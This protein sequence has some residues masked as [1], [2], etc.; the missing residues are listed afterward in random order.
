MTAIHVQY[1]FG[2]ESPYMYSTPF[3]A[4]SPVVLWSEPPPGRESRISYR[5]GRTGVRFRLA[6]LKVVL[7]YFVQRTNQRKNESQYMYNKR[8][9]LG[10]NTLPRKTTG[11]SPTSRSGSTHQLSDNGPMAQLVC[12][13]YCGRATQTY[14]APRDESFVGPVA[15]QLRQYE[16]S[17]F[18]AGE[19][20]RQTA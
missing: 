4:E 15:S 20:I 12:H 17:C 11:Q 18:P 6:V 13:F 19:L 2:A 1:P 16:R 14:L 10:T 9:F 8:H 3:G 7:F 5:R